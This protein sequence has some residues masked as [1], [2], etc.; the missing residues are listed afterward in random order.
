MALN[1]PAASVLRE[2]HIGMPAKAQ[3]PFVQ[4]VDKGLEIFVGGAVLTELVIL[5]ANVITRSF[6]DFTILWANEFGHLVLGVV[7]FVGGALA[8]NRNE[9]IAVH[10]V[11][12]RLPTSWR[13]ALDSFVDW[14]VAIGSA[15]VAYVSVE[16][17]K[18][19]SDELSTVMEISMRWFV[20]PL[21]A[22]LVLMAFFALY[23]LSQ[24]AKTA[25]VA[26]GI[27]FAV[28]LG[29]LATLNG[30]WGPFEDSSFV[31]W[32]TIVFFA[33][34]MALGL[35]VGFVLA[36]VATMFTYFS[37]SESMIAIPSTM[38]AG[39]S[40]FVL[41]AIPF[42]M[43]AGYVMTEGGLSG[44]LSDFVVSVVGRVRGGLYQV[45]VVS[46]YIFSGISG[47]KA[48]DVAA[49]GTSLKKMIRD[50]GYDEPEFAAILSAG[51]VMGETIPPS[52]PMLVL[53]SITTISMGALFMAG[54]LPALVLA[55]CLMGAIYVKARRAGK[56]PGIKTPMAVVRRNTLLAAP[57]LLVPVLLVVGIVT[58]L[59]TPTEISSVA[60]VYGLVL[61][62]VLYRELTLKKFWST[63]S[64]TA[65]KGGMILFITSTASSFAYTLTAAGI[66]TE[67]ADLMIKMAGRTDWVFMLASLLILI[68]MGALL[69]GLPALLVFAPILMP[70]APKFGVSPIQYGIVLLI[71]MGIGCFAPLIGVGM[72]I[73]CS[74]T[75]TKVE[76]A[77]RA[78]IPYAILLFAGLLLVAFVPWFSLVLPR[79][80]GF[81]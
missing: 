11:I 77:S 2:G 72:Y 10:A 1:I 27:V 24:R 58:G 40:N 68:V 18:S 28:V 13:P 80:F 54:L 4:R 17:V 66:P 9:H 25:A 45:I 61:S 75:G 65:I 70:L 38:Q 33:I 44:R 69:E 73:S 60:V 32:L 55:L 20:L 34:F 46:M 5:F 47:S 78:M 67:I 81:A 49:V 42:F 23:R 62:L 43:M 22:G 12:E 31:T 41:L 63:V 16:V 15:Y 71:A 19:R 29:G 36:V 39:V 59:A 7:A 26:S 3:H 30:V 37:G 56:Y 76:A 50:N 35:P 21:T 6:F 79:L 14:M 52:L 8:Y 48:A 74:V 53:G 51:A 57:A 64:D